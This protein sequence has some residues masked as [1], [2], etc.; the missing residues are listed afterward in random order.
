[1]AIGR[2]V[3]S[4]PTGEGTMLLIDKPL[5]WTSF[6][7]VH[8]VRSLLKG[9]KVGHAGTLDPKATG[10]LIVCTGR[11]TKTMNQFVDL[12]KEYVGAFELGVRT[13]SHDSET[14]ALE[15]RD[16]SAVTLEAL[17]SVAA[18]FVGKQ[19]QRPPMYSAVKHQGKPLYIYA[20]KGRTVQKEPREVEI[21]QFEI[22]SFAPPMAEFRVVCSKGTYVRSLVDDVGAALGCGAT[23]RSLRRTR[24][25]PYRVEDA[26]SIE[27]LSS[28]SV[29]VPSEQ[30][31]YD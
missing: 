18:R 6:D 27:D 10:L 29:D 16:P 11:R 21:L 9:A 13:A 7:V 3:K 1:M 5:D 15:R 28:L 20:R 14:D 23:L 26:L 19:L 30:R 31:T 25:G 12:E 24:I 22:R 17:R 8:R 4:E 2:T